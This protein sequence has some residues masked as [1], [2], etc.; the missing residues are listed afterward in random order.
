MSETED[1]D[2]KTI[3]QDLQKTEGLRNAFRQLGEVRGYLRMK[4]DRPWRTFTE[5]EREAGCA[6][7]CALS[8]LTNCGDGKTVY[9]TT[10]ERCGEILELCLVL[11]DNLKE[12]LLACE[13]NLAYLAITKCA[14]YVYLV[15]RERTEKQASNA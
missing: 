15:Q 11:L 5:N 1:N 10:Y 6:L 4:E 8:I 7:R 2:V 13:Y 14:Q 12:Q 9:E 3:E